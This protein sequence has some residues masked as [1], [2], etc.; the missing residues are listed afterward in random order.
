M[1]QHSRHLSVFLMAIALAFLMGCAATETTQA[2]G[3]YTDDATTTAK[4]KQAI[5][6]DSELKVM[7]ISVETFRG[8]V[9]LSGFVSSEE[10]AA[11]AV[12]VAGNVNGVKS[13]K[14]DMQIR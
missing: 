12:A 3:E 2:P 9:Q 11:R 13:V 10:A 1:K 8:E 14:N 7:E 6:S 4:V 5:F